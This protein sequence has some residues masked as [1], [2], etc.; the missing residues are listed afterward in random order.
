M[1]AKIRSK[2]RRL[3]TLQQDDP[4]RTFEG[5]AAPHVVQHVTWHS[6]ESESFVEAGSVSGSK[7]ARGAAELRRADAAL[8]ER[9]S[10][11]E[12]LQRLH[13]RTVQSLMSG[14]LTIDSEGVVT[15]FNPEA[16]R[17]TGHDVSSAVGRDVDETRRLLG[18]T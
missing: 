5:G 15:S 8:S 18:P 14:L 1:L 7:R 3:L 16:E 6:A 9:T 13:E 17:I 12:R 11:L 2:A 4:R 10:D